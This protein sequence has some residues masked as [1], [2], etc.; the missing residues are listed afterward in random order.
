MPSEPGRIGRA[1]HRSGRAA[2]YLQ[3]YGTSENAATYA[4]RIFGTA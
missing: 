3:E 1:L 4:L 2:T